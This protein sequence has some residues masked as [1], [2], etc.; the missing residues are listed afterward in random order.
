MDTYLDK[1]SHVGGVPGGDVL[2]NQSWLEVRWYPSDGSQEDMVSLLRFDLSGIP[3]GSTVTSATLTLYNIRAAANTSGSSVITL[4]NVQTAWDLTWS[5]NKGVP[6]TAP[7]T[8]VCPSTVPYTLSPNPPEVYTI[9]GLESLVQGW[10]NAPASNFGLMLSTSTNL[11]MRF[12]SSRYATAQYRPA[13]QLTYGPPSGGTPPQVT[14]TAPPAT[15]DSSP[16]IVS[17]TASGS[18]SQVTWSNAATGESGVATGTGSWTA[19][20]PLAEGANDITITATDAAGLQ[21]STTFT[22]M[23]TAAVPPSQPSPAGGGG[24][25]HKACGLGAV[26]DA[27]GAAC[28]LALGIALVLIRLS[29]RSFPK[30]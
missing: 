25:G 15:T 20:I 21:G 30:G 18:V 22:V 11:N 8:V 29:R 12:G 28:L 13:L 5:W 9:A 3:Q 26:H 10:V 16:L 4:G 7:T 27:P 14:I 2:G 24:G 19:T 6:T 17:G 23:Y 1:Y